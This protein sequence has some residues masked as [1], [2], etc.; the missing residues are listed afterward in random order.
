MGRGGNGK[1]AKAPGL[2]YGPRSPV[3]LMPGTDIPP[4]LGAVK[5]LL[6][7]RLES[8][9]ISQLAKLPTTLVPNSKFA[10]KTVIYRSALLQA[11]SS[12]MKEY[13][14]YIAVGPSSSDPAK[15]HF[16]GYT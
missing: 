8:E 16:Y 5:A 2:L 4:E 11:Q 15:P 9:L 1:Q 7:G 6:E 3:R 14:G 13:Q 12:T 10:G